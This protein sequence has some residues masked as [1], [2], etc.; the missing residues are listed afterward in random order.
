M[1]GI[2]SPSRK[3][4][5]YG[6]TLVTMKNGKV[7]KEQNYFDNYSFLSQLGLINHKLFTNYY[8]TP[9]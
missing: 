8:L 1:S 2:P 3:I 5:L 6:V 9:N 4:N 7:L